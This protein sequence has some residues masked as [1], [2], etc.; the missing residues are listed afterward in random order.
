[1]MWFFFEPFS[2]DITLRSKTT[3]KST[4]IWCI[5]LLNCCWFCTSWST[6]YAM[7]DMPHY[8]YWKYLFKSALWYSK[9]TE[10]NEHIVQNR[11]RLW[12]ISNC[13]CTVHKVYRNTFP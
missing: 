8:W 11:V 10:Q 6:L 7:K 12:C 3:L 2:K 13:L 5:V 1:M 9:L 4:M